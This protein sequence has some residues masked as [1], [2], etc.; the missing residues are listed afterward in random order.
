VGI[1]GRKIVAIGALQHLIAAP[2]VS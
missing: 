1:L 2:S